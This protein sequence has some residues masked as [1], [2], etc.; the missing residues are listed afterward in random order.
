M[1][2]RIYRTSPNY[3]SPPQAGALIQVG[4]MAIINWIHRHGLPAE[5]LPSGHYRIPREEFL[6]WAKRRG[7]K[8]KEVAS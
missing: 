7:I 3:L 4:R 5:I 6:S 2:T 1:P 8:L